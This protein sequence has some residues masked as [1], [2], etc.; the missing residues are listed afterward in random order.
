M[1][2]RPTH[3]GYAYQDLLTAIRL[4]DV[5]LGRAA[6]VIVDTKMFA[7]DLFDDVTTEWRA[8]NRERLQIKHT[9]SDRELTEASFARDRRGLRLDLLISAI[10]HDLREHPGTGYRIVMRD[11]EPYSSDLVHV[12]APTDPGTD[13]GPALQGLASTRWRFDADR[14]RETEPWQ[15]ILAGTDDDA[16]RGAC[17]ALV[18][19][20]GVPG[21]SLDIREPGPAERVLLRR[22]V[23]ELGA[24]RPPNR[25]R[26][27]EDV[28]LAL[29]EAAKAARSLNG[30][31]TAR[32]LVPRLG[33]AVDF[34]AVREGHPVDRAAEI[35]RPDVLAM[36]IGAVNQAAEQGGTVVLTGGPGI[37]KSWLCEQLADQL[38]ED[39][40]IVARHHCWLGT[41]DT[42]RDR[43]VLA[44]VV[45]GSLLRQLETVEPGAVSEIR[46]RYA[47]T[48]ETLTMAVA[49]IMSEYPYRRVV[50]IVD[51]LDHVTRVLGRTVGTAF[52]DSADPAQALVDEL[53]ALDLPAGAVLLL[54]SQPGPHLAT[55]S[56]IAADAAVTVPALNRRE[57]R[58]LAERLGVLAA[59]GPAEDVF[60]AGGRADTAV[61]LIHT[62][63][64]GNALYVTYLCRQ[65]LGP[66]PAF[67][68]HAPSAPLTDP[69]DRLRDVPASARDLD[70]YYG[71]LLAGLTDGQRAAVSLLAVCDF[72]VT[73]DELGEIFPAAAPMLSMALAAMAPVIA[74]QP[75]IGGL[76]IHHESFSRFVRHHA[77]VGEKWAVGIR[78]A[79]A[80]WLARR[81]FFT[82]T[83]AFRHLPELLAA[84]GR[85]DELRALIGPDFLSRAIAGLQPP[86]AI[87][88]TLAVAAGHSA[89]HCDWP[90][91]IRCV[92]FRRAADT[93]GDEGISGTVV[94]SADV[95]V[96]LLGA[97]PMAASLVYDG[98][99]TLPPRE[100]LHLCAAID[101]VGAAAPWDVY[102]T[103]WDDS[104]RSDDA[105]HSNSDDVF[106]AELRGRLR[107]PR[108]ADDTEGVTVAQ[109]AASFLSQ[110]GL[111]DLPQVVAVL[112]DCLGMETLLDAV[113]LLDDPATRGAVLIYLADAS[114]QAGH[115]LPSPRTLAVAAWACASG[116]DPRLLVDHGVPA[117]DLCDAF[118]GR[119]VDATLRA[120]TEEVLRDP[121]PALAH[122]VRRWLAL[123]AVAHEQHPRAATQLLPCLDGVGFF[124]AWLRFAVATV[125]LAR[126]LTAG[127]LTREA[128]SA[129]VRT[130][131]GQLAQAAQP[132]T[133]K[134][135]ASDLWVIHAIVHEVVQ[136]AIAM[137]LPAD[138]KPALASLN[139]ISDG[140]TTSLMGMAG[141]GPLITTDLLAILS[142]TV[143]QTGAAVVHRL[144][145]QL[146][147]EHANRDA[148]YPESATFELEMARA[149][150][151]AGDAAEAR[152]CWE[153][154]AR[155]MA[156]YGSHKDTTIYELLAPLPDLAAADLDRARTRLASLQPLAYLVAQNTDGRSTSQVPRDWW[157]RLADLDPRAAA[158]L[159]AE[160]LL[161]EPGLPS[162]LVDAAHLQLLGGEAD[163]ADPVI[164]AALRVAAG[165]GGRDLDRDIALLGR[166]ACLPAA[167]PAWAAGIQPVL[168]NAITST[169]DDQPLMH[170]S[171]ADGP[172]PTAVL[173]DAAQV[174]GGEGVT[175]RQPRPSDDGRERG[176][177][178][179]AISIP[180]VLHAQQRPALP[181]GAVG[182]L[183]AIR[184][185]ASKPYDDDPAAPRWAADA[186]ANAAGWRLIQVAADEGA[187][188]AARLL[189]RI[190]D[191]IGD[192]GAGTLLADIATGLE[193]RRESGPGTL[194]RLASIA[195]T[196]AF[197][198]IR[199]GGGWLTF[200]GRDRLDLW[201]RA[202]ALDPDAASLCLAQQVAAVVTGRKYGTLGV[203]QALIEAFA[204]R[205]ADPAVPGQPDPFT[206]WD[207]A[208]SVI[209]YRLPGSAKIL[210]DAYSPATESATR[211]DIDTALSRLT[212]ATLAMPDRADRRRA[213]VAATV[214]LTARP[215]EAQAAA[216]RVL[217]ADLG[218]GPLTWLLTALRERLKGTPITDDLA[219]QLASLARSDLLSVRAEA[220]IILS[221]AGRP[222]P[223]PPATPAHPALV[224]A[225]TEDLQ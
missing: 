193:L 138:L 95:L 141:S 29:I 111:P 156:A 20:V 74:H 19:E 174:L 83:R 23:D 160:A 210:H 72:A 103:A 116:P 75:G 73:A 51:G 48:A 221:M 187:D 62:R 57:V 137:L 108:R 87:A 196:L 159:S 173:R 135:K 183:T 184:D 194:D 211:Q 133:G 130:A 171:Q 3:L 105:D 8:G 53:A 92:E 98:V 25:H 36:A 204:A 201:H 152:R 118:L 1:G 215:A 180:A 76:K 77:S 13:P 129:V 50:L 44:D 150:L 39:G 110:D 208:F 11:T 55:V 27:P 223:S 206:C 214:L 134:P 161:G 189:H 64:R 216:A 59:F 136:D 88:H 168:A 165:P 114:A 22:A 69:L 131:L 157:R 70:D 26:E 179:R 178:P 167:D 84:L 5:A 34:G 188:A 209:A 119:D 38:Q 140:T 125:G 49:E 120:A 9:D 15:A 218:A 155:Y 163:T 68:D 169:Y 7:G 198:K 97:S 166:L 154:A 190:A 32:D 71:Y 151:N 30:T 147:D 127:T 28:A 224:R 90:T 132:F 146:R 117:A 54:A 217:A 192:F 212:L 115:G 31:V 65:A 170:A 195:Y 200:A 63:S 191:E 205:S 106:L 82:D 153:R 10:D 220:A 37:G 112:A 142:R 100:G 66:D 145:S 158:D 46:P 122:A 176:R 16:L 96:S 186:L 21:C 41:D 213:L 149:S 6:Q 40:A 91:L 175:P 67:A 181:P 222:V 85:D 89:A 101:R 2:L 58:D 80:D 104:R 35:S 99:P 139:A 128:A 12:L 109:R 14:L 124:R 143:D 172:E 177:G 79:A 126:D 102:L 162:G 4:V 42:N 182:V 24:G 60:N 45:V 47:A 219:G 52:Q 197:A 78:S 107:L 121:N 199:G 17:E 123:L 61:A 225:A 185:H 94:N 43:R 148:Q 203:T 93:Y 164:L 144:M 86:A 33:L 113:A 56:G 81:G 207:A 202:Q 18:V